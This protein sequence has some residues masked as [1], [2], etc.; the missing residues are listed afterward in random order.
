MTASKTTAALSSADANSPR[1]T[2]ASLRAPKNIERAC[3]YTQQIDPR[4]LLNL[5][6]EALYRAKRNGRKRMELAAPPDARGNFP[7]GSR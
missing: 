4:S 3:I 1:E 5:A 6:D 7:S 2:L